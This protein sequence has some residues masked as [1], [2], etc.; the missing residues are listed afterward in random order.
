MFFF[1]DETYVC[2][3]YREC[4]SLRHKNTENQNQGAHEPFAGFFPVDFRLSNQI[5]SAQATD[6]LVHL[7]SM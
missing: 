4:K 7:E 1:G 6:A 5:R 2:I 3:V